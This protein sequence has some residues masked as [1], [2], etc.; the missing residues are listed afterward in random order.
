MSVNSY[1]TA[2]RCSGAHCQQPFDIGLLI[3]CV[4]CSPFVLPCLRPLAPGWA[5]SNP[6][7][8]CW[9]GSLLSPGSQSSPAA[10][11]SCS[12]G[13]SPRQTDRQLPAGHWQELWMFPQTLRAS[14]LHFRALSGVNKLQGCYFSV[15]DCEAC[16]SARVASCASE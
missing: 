4:S 5:C 10:K 8:L 15:G 14:G 13:Q 16:L 9:C 6:C 1:C 12:T 2:N 11:P 3:H 7:Y